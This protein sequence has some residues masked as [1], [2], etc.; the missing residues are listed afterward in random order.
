VIGPAVGQEGDELGSGARALDEQPRGERL[1]LVDVEPVQ[2]APERALAVERALHHGLDDRSKCQ[3]IPRRDEVERGP[4]QP[5]PDRATFG[6]RPRQRLGTEA[7]EPRPE[8]D[9]GVARHLGLQADQALDG[10]G[11]RDPAPSEQQL[12]FEQRAVE[13]AA[14]EDARCGRCQLTCVPSLIQF[15]RQVTPSS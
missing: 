12:A 5:H 13:R 10:V 7:I 2:R 9:V 4:E 14:P 3:G 11:H 6:D 8:R 15:V 1:Q